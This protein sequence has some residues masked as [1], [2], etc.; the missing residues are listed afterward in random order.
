[1]FV[2]AVRR[3][4]WAGARASLRVA[5]YV[6]VTR[7]LALHSGSMRTLD[8]GAGAEEPLNLATGL[9][10][11]LKDKNED[12]EEKEGW[13]LVDE[14]VAEDE[15]NPMLAHGAIRE[16]V[17]KLKACQDGHGTSSPEITE[18]IVEASLLHVA[19]IAEGL[20]PEEGGVSVELVD[21]DGTVFED[22]W[23]RSAALER[24]DV[25]GTTSSHLEDQEFVMV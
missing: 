13:V 23:D 1:M 5:K 11:G 15:K 12:E 7:P 4:A 3:A 25:A 22:A 2:C 21:E 17:D 16:L 9:N 19:K 18:E 8:A 10:Q 14:G 24:I 6:L 20:K